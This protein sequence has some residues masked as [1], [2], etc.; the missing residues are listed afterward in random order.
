VHRYA[1][2]SDRLLDE[3]VAV[4]ADQIRKAA[5]QSGRRVIPQPS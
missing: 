2:L 5:G 3:A 4:V 1:H